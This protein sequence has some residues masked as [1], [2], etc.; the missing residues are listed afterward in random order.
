MT[1]GDIRFDAALPSERDSA[2]E[3]A[4]FLDYA[5]SD[6]LRIDRE[7]A[8]LLILAISRLRSIADGSTEP[9]SPKH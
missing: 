8:A 2:R 9:L 3:L 5:K 6:V 7:A 4:A 1:I